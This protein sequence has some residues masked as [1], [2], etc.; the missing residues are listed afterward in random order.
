MND[1]RFLED[2]V[3]Q[4]AEKFCWKVFREEPG[5][6]YLV[7]QGI[8]AARVTK[9]VYQTVL[10]KLVAARISHRGWGHDKN[11]TILDEDLFVD[12]ACKSPLI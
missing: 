3:G 5:E 4:R 9:G 11:K 7:Y 10:I 12:L 6:G 8:Y 1:T 2:I